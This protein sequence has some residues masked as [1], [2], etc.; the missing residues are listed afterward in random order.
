M[1]RIDD[2]FRQLRAT[3]R[4]GLMPF[5]CAGS[6]V[7]GMLPD[8]LAAAERAGAC[9]AEIG[10]PFSDPVADG[11]VIAEAM[12]GA[13]RAGVTPTG[14]FDEIAAARTRV[15]LGL[16]A[17]VSVSIVWRL[18]VGEVAARARDAG[19]DGFILPDLPAGEEDALLQ[20]LRDAGFSVSLLVAPTTS[21][22]RAE[23]IAR[24]CSGFVYLLARAGI[25]G[26]SGGPPSAHAPAALSTTLP[27]RIAMLRSMT[28]L[29]IACG[30]G[31]STSDHVRAVTAHADAAIVGSALVRAV[32]EAHQAG[33]DPVAAAESLIHTLAQGLFGPGRP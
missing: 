13:L 27:Q 28:D 18:G 20:T 33:G 10:I 32:R 3:Q 7:P 12:N 15:N 8:L 1:G 16:V 4:R 25:T 14:A 21:P 2:I 30:F 24:S 19:V 9:I 29:P 31:I 6:P 22:E 26:E 11:P 23:R 5:F 17:M